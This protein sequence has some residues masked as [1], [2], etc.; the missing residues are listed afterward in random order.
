MLR[1]SIPGADWGTARTFGYKIG[2][3]GWQ[4]KKDID[5]PDP[6]NYSYPE[7]PEVTFDWLPDQ[8]IEFGL[9][10]RGHVWD[11]KIIGQAADKGPLAIWKAQNRGMIKQ[12][13][14]EFDYEIVDCPGPPR[15]KDLSK[16][17]PALH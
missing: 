5:W 4:Y 3:G 14:R 8:S 1:G 7:P 15:R 17:L 12:D 13:D 16:A 2:D 9:W 6:S 10:Q 11:S